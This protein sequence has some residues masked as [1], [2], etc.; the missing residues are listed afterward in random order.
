MNENQVCNLSN[1]DCEPCQGGLPA[2]PSD[3]A[4]AMHDKLHSD[5]QLSSN[6]TEI[7]R[8]FKFKGFARAVQMANLIAWVGDQQG[9]ILI[10]LSVG[11]IVRLPL[12]PM[13]LMGYRPMTLS[14]QQN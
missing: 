5:W 7:S 1:R 10:L 13:K 6:S 9:I 2:L 3:E 11:V 14:A 12:P 4:K 8:Q